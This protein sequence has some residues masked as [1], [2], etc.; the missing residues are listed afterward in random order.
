M[1]G[2]YFV[3]YNVNDYAPVP[4]SAIEK[5]RTVNIVDNVNDVI[6]I[7]WVIIEIDINNEEL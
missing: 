7:K 2:I 4:N 1:V 3:K 5:T 6:C